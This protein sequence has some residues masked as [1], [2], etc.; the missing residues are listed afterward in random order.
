MLVINFKTY[1][2]GDKALELSRLIE[3]KHPKAIVCASSI[4]LETLHQKTSLEIFAQHVDLIKGR[5]G[6]GYVTPESIKTSGASGTLLNHFEHQIPL[7]HIKK[8]VKRCK[9]LGLKTIVCV[10]NLKEA[11]KV[12]KIKPYAIAFEAPSLIESGKSI[13]DHKREEVLEFVKLFL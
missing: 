13:T 3:K 9:V 2:L 8:A 11:K 12:L 7:W 6:T 4:D 5:R 1:K 10:K